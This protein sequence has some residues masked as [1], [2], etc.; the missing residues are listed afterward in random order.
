MAL[1]QPGKGGLVRVSGGPQQVIIAG[2]VGA[3]GA[4]KT[5]LRLIKH[6]SARIGSKRVDGGAGQACSRCSGVAL[7]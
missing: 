3:V 1:Q 6:A 4:W 5:F 2:A 7:E